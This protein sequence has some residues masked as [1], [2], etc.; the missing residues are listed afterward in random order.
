MY[1]RNRFTPNE[2]VGT[3]SSE[4]PPS[5]RHVSSGRLLD[6]NS[7]AL[8]HCCTMLW[9]I[10]TP[11]VDEC[12]HY[13]LYSS[14]LS[15]VPEGYVNPDHWWNKKKKLVCREFRNGPLLDLLL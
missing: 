8:H 9:M 10:E 14:G 2:V 11:S 7:E 4:L 12:F 15:G 13:H 3:V 6:L 1:P 5:Q